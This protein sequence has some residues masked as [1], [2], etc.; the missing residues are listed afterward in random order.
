[1]IN[2]IDIN[3]FKPLTKQQLANY[4]LQS[5]AFVGDAVFS[6]FVRT[7]IALFS[8][9]KS[10]SLH[11]ASVAVVKATAQSEILDKLMPF[12][13]D[14]EAALATRARNTKVNAPTKKATRAEYMKSTAY[15]ALLGCL[16]LGGE[17][18]RLQEILQMSMG[19]IKEE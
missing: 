3:T 17:N 10:G 2:L 11:K 9:G 4:N 18:K 6:L 8:T 1:M 14:E 13:T 7:Q 16:Y 12:L 19:F 5:L 15:E